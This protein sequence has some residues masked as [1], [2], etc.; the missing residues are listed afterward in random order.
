LT[1][2]ED[3]AAVFTRLY[4]PVSVLWNGSTVWALLEGHPDDVREQAEAAGV[5][6]CDGPPPLPTGSRRSLAPTDVFALE[7]DFVAELGVGI[8][9]HA[10]PWQPPVRGER[11]TSLARALKQQFDPDG[12]LNPGIDV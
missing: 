3:A 7:G 12:R 11:E 10:E 1:A 8:V 4:R 6:E 9:H 2:V 5:T